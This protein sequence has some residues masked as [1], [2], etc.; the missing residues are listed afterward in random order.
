MIIDREIKDEEIEVLLTDMLEKYGY[1]FT[2]YSKASLK[3]RI[4]R[5]VLM[6]KFA[7]FAE[8]RSK[9]RTDTSYFT[10]FVEEITVNVTEMFRDPQFY[11]TLRQQVIPALATSPF[12]R[13]W[14]AGCSTGEEV[15][16]TAILLHEA[17]LLEKSKI[18]A[19]DINPYVLAKAR[20]GVFTEIQLQN[21][22]E[23]Y[24]LAGGEKD[25]RSYFIHTESGY[26]FSEELSSHIGFR[27]HSLASA[28][29]LNSFDLIFCRNVLIYFDKT[30]RER[31]LDLLDVS[32]GPG[33]FLVL[34]ERETLKFSF[35]EPGFG[36]CGEEPIWRKR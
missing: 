26:K 21:Y 36:Q 30:L 11:S 18:V 14:H 23:N 25:F 33:S 4:N 3:R 9:I 13:I 34:G 22:E 24:R 8:L 27:F 29:Y 15:Y 7:D 20:T 35:I 16:S 10:R 28:G 5:I 6:D 2:N 1:D 17:G 32:M 31:A 19:T 12:I